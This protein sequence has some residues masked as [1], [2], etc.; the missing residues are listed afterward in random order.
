M[1][2]TVKRGIRVHEKTEAKYILQKTQIFVLS[3]I[4]LHTFFCCIRIS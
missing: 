3:F 4:F 2:D 1:H